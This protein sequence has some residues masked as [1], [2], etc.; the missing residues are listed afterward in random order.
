[1]ES[2]P[3]LMNESTEVDVSRDPGTSRTSVWYDLERRTNAGNV[4]GY[5]K[6]R[7]GSG[8]FG[9]EEADETIETP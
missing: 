9:T 4:G 6:V 1:M 8:N 3:L 2:Q 7:K 5:Q